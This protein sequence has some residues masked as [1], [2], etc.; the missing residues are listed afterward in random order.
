MATLV[1]LAEL[2]VTVFEVGARK[3]ERDVADE[4]CADFDL[5]LRSL[6]TEFGL[7]NGR[8]WFPW[9]RTEF[10]KEVARRLAERCGS[11]EALLVSVAASGA[12]FLDMVEGIYAFLARAAATTSGDSQE[13]RF[14]MGSDELS[15][16][17]SPAFVER[18]RVIR[19]TLLRLQVGAIDHEKLRDFLRVDGDFYGT[20]PLRSQSVI[21]RVDQRR[22]A[23]DLCFLPYV[24]DHVASLSPTSPVH[25][26]WRSADDAAKKFVSIALRLVRAHVRRLQA[27]PPEDVG[28]ESDQREAAFYDRT[29]RLGSGIHRPQSAAPA[30]PLLWLEVDVAEL[31][32]HPISMG[33]SP[34]CVIEVLPE[35]DAH[36]RRSALGDLACLCAI[37]KA[38]LVREPDPHDEGVPP[39]DDEL[40]AWL[41]DLARRLLEVTEWLQSEVWRQTGETTAF[42]FTDVIE[43][44]LRLPLWSERA[45]LYEVWLTTAAVGVAE[46][47]GWRARLNLVRGARGERVW[48]LRAR[49][50]RPCVEL[51]PRKAD[52]PIVEVWREPRVQRWTPDIVFRERS[53]GAYLVVIEAK[54]RG[55]MRKR[56]RGKGSLDV[57]ER[58]VRASLA[59]VTWVANYCEFPH[60]E[61]Q[62]P[63]RNHGNA[64]TRLHFGSALKPG[65]VPREFETTLA[66]ALD[67]RPKARGRSSRRNLRMRQAIVVIHGVGEQRP[68]ETLRDFVSAIAPGKVRSKPDRLSES[69]ELR[70]FNLVEDSGQGL[71]STD[72]YELYWAHH[73]QAGRWGA[74]FAWM[75]RLILRLPRRVPQRL[76]STYWAT[77]S[78]SVS[79]VV[80]AAIA[81]ARA[82]QNDEHSLSDFLTWI[83]TFGGAVLLVA[84]LVFGRFVLRYI[85]DAARYLT[86]EPENI[87]SR[88]KLRAEGV[89]LL[90][91]LHEGGVYSR[92][93]V[94]G[95]SLGSVIG[96]DVL[97]HLWDE[98][99]F[100]RFEV[101]CRQP[102]ASA[103]QQEI[104]K[105]RT[106][107]EEERGKAIEAFQQAQHRLWR[108]HRAAGIPWLVTDFVTLGSPLAHAELLLDTKAAAVRQREFE[109]ELPTCPP[110]SGDEPDLYDGNVHYL[111]TRDVTVD[112]S[113]RKWSFRVPNHGAV[114]C[115]TRWTNLFFPHR[116]LVLGDLIG[117]PLRDVLGPGIRDVRL[118]PSR[119]GILARTLCSHVLYWSVPSS[120]DRRKEPTKTSLAD[121]RK[122]GTKDA[123]RALRSALRLEAARSSSPWPPPADAD[124]TP[125]H[126][127]NE[128]S[129]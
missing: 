59:R 97:R 116:C 125:S 64:R 124:S 79:T 6:E 2:F 24:G 102:E 77:W 107:P 61:L 128:A 43:E 40:A 91:K 46:S 45:V 3:A 37:W 9:T 90:R 51:T 81:I 126:R 36:T 10:R 70:R 21:S 49:S 4:V 58:Y 35:A 53:S 65:N 92:V 42:D 98:L 100:P 54:D 55:A 85:G 31:L 57:A 16:T 73:M 84:Q 28:V 109:R 110:T 30:D 88:S 5:D 83:A 94:V 63:G 96:Y 115:S 118:R 52:G 50:G 111:E 47:L 75:L 8:T 95:H 117:G 26:A 27:S 120:E 48:Q 38:G 104:S 66:A 76:R 13:F 1:E 101:P 39:R 93:V 123:L 56:G 82:M 60:R 113:R 23:R 11:M 15:L 87:E 69:F 112:G 20:W 89:R 71:P 106:A 44:F 108:E 114:F 103:F 41:H 119:P 99:R 18:I 29:G 14:Q 19:A 72:V 105:V 62:D 32:R 78:A 67:P 74:T 7:K 127:S 33:S 22:V 34:G 80:L 17:I 122:L 25:Q 129:S 12:A 121:D 86:P 68:M